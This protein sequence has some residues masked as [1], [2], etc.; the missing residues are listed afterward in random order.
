MVQNLAKL[1]FQSV[2]NRPEDFYAKIE[3]GTVPSFD[4]LVTNPPYSGDHMRKLLQFA[5]QCGKPWLLLVPNYVYTL[6]CYEELVGRDDGSNNAAS[7]ASRS[8]LNGCSSDRPVFLCPRQRYCYRS[9]ASH[10]PNISA[11]VCAADKRKSNQR[12]KYVAPFYTFWYIG[13]QAHKDRVLRWWCKR[14]EKEAKERKGVAVE[15][16]V[17]ARE[18]G[19]EK[20]GCVLCKSLGEL[21]P[22]ARSSTN[23]ESALAKFRKAFN[24]CCRSQGLGKLCTE[25]AITGRCGCA[26]AKTKSPF[27][28]DPPPAHTVAAASLRQLLAE[29]RSGLMAEAE[30]GTTAHAGLMAA[31]VAGEA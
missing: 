29:H 14:E 27:S 8:S 15:E 7:N 13:L 10:R 24:D 25:Y 18:G 12:L 3:A 17:E 16:A 26:N 9:K 28:H 11:A 5:T 1:G 6:A 19:G 31:L 4:V 20:R 22:F 2:Y 23:K 30:A 21:P